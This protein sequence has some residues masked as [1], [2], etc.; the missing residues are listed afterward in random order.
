M[1]EELVPRAGWTVICEIEQAL[2]NITKKQLANAQNYEIIVTDILES[3]NTINYD[4]VNALH[5]AVNKYHGR[6]LLVSNL[7]YSIA[8]PTMINL[9]TTPGIIA[10]AMY[11]TI[12]KE[13]AQRMTAKPNSDDYGAISIL[14]AV[15]EKQN[16]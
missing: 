7:P 16:F 3:K 14:M 4:V 9:I 6:L 1:T 5:Q 12:Q 11:V 2:A 10:D 8:C 13:V 15:T